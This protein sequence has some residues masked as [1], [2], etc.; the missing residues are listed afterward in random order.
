[1]PYR[2]HRA[3]VQR[4]EDIVAWQL[5]VALRDAIGE[6]T[7]R[8]AIA[9]DF[10]FCPPNPRLGSLA[11]AQYLRGVRPLSAT[12]LRPLSRHRLRVAHGDEEQ[13]AGGSVQGIPGR[14]RVLEAGSTDHPRE[15]SDAQAAAVSAHLQTT[16]LGAATSLTSSN[17]FEP[18]RTSSNLFEP[19]RTSSNPPEPPRTSSNLLEPPRTPS[20]PLEPPRTP[21]N[22]LEP[23]RTS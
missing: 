19:L 8:P 15:Q 3:R 4:F 1:M 20:N 17:L 5:S 14:S 10:K 2:R 7:A 9:R 18:L 6:I 21:S 12:R 13:S 22:P 16:T 11:A 23:P